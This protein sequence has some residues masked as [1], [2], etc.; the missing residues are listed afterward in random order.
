MTGTSFAQSMEWE[1]VDAAIGRGATVS[2]DVHR[3]GFPR[4]DTNVSLDGV[5]LKPAFALGGWVAFKPMN[6]E[7]MVMGDIVLLETEIT[8]VMTKPIENGIE[9]TAIHNHL[10]HAKPI[11][12]TL[13]AT[14]TRS[15]WQ[16]PFA[17][18]WPQAKHH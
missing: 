6:A 18:D 13:A 7:V 12:C 11:T 14:V 17:P 1:K 9:I 4:T 2:G 10:L 8:P 15:T 16:Q 5:I 3:Y